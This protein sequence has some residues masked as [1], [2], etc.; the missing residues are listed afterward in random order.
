MDQEQQNQNPNIEPA[1]M[2]EKPKT[3]GGVG[4]LIGSIIVIVLLII[5]T[6][7]LWNTKISERVNPTNE[8]TPKTETP[9]SESNEV[10]ALENDLNQTIIDIQTEFN[11]L[12]I[13]I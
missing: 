6:I 4:A 7:Y 10:N 1:P 13:N 5:G 3:D 12:E 8:N 2:P 9:L 11:D